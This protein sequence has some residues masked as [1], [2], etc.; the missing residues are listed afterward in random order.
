MSPVSDPLIEALKH[1][2][3]GSKLPEDLRELQQALA[4]GWITIASNGGVAIGGDV[5]GGIVAG[6]LN[7]VLPPEILKLLQLPQPVYQPPAFPSPEV[8]AERGALPPGSRLSFSPNKVFTGRQEDLLELARALLYAQ[9][10]ED[11]DQG[12]VVTGMGGLGKTQL[13]VEFCYR[14]GRFF[15]GVHWLNAMDMQAEIAENGLA[16]RLAMKLPYWPDKLP[17]QVQAT[18]NAWQDGGQRLIVLDNAENP[19]SATGLASKAL[20]GQAIDHLPS[21]ELAGR[22]GSEGQEP[23]GAGPH[24]KHRAAAE[25]GC[26]AEG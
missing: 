17:E 12:L 21:G 9:D 13:A 19:K 5:S 1:L 22:P 15:Q 26:H 23:G 7:L 3:S 16:M 18:L 11:M 6:S 10:S 8:L 14:Y 20:A 24:P 4:S 2:A 25:T